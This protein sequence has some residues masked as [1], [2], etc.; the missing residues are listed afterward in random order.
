MKQRNVHG[1]NYRIVLNPENYM[2]SE[3]RDDQTDLFKALRNT[4]QQT[5]ITN[6]T[7]TDALNAYLRSL[8]E[9]ARL[10]MVGLYHEQEAFDGSGLPAI[11]IL[12]IIARTRTYRPVYYYR[13]RFDSISWKGGWMKIEADIDGEYVLPVVWNRK[14]FIFWVTFA[15]KQDPSDVVM[16]GTGEPVRGNPGY[17][18]VG[19]SWCMLN[20][21][22]FSARYTSQNTFQYDG[23][24]SLSAASSLVL[25]SSVASDGGQL[26][27]AVMRLARPSTVDYFTFNSVNGTP[28]ATRSRSR[29]VYP[30]TKHPGT[31]MQNMML[32]EDGS[33][34][35]VLALNAGSKAAT[36]LRSTP[37][38]P[39]ELVTS[40]QDRTYQSQRPLFFQHDERA[41]FVEPQPVTFY[42]PW[43]PIPKQIDPS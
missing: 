38:R 39:Y 11:D 27:L 3:L 9:M 5:D 14:L 23:V 1:A 18:E 7:V 19:L 25:K 20:G 24:D 32:V 34:N 22:R 33:N 6:D 29:T 31:S 4:L 13:Q 12:H 8:D 28:L 42:V 17:I 36:V 10:Q 37:G 2:Q 40:S 41:F 21:E 30:F 43:I 16:P 15:W 26:Q 35:H